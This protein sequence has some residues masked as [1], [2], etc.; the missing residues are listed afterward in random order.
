MNRSPSRPRAP[1]VPFRRRL[2]VRF[3]HCDPAGIVFFPRYLEM[4]NDLFEDF[5]AGLGHPFAA[6]HGSDAAPGAETG[7]VP[8]VRVEAD[9]LAPSRLGDQLELTLGVA[10]LGRSSVTLACEARALPPASV[11]PNAGPDAGPDAEAGAGREA[12]AGEL[13]WRARQVVVWVAN[14]RRGG[15]LA[16][17]PLP[18]ALRAALREHLLPEAEADDAA[19]P[20]DRT[21]AGVTS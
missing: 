12:G 9:F 13:R 4:L 6:L 14:N 8:T 20:D 11:S 18:E 19:E 15:A 21:S 10:R 5:M 2:T 1:A 17:R 7:G 16:T 3:R